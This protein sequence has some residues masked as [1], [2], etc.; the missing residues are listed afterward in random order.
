MARSHLRYVIRNRSGRVIEGALVELLF[1]GEP[2]EQDVFLQAEGGEPTSDALVSNADGEVEA[3]FDEGDFIPGTITLRV[4][5]NDGAAHY[6]E[7]PDEA[8]EWD[9]F[10]ETVDVYPAPDDVETGI[11][12]LPEIDSEGENEGDILKV[13]MGGPVWAPE[14]GETNDEL[15]VKIVYDGDSRMLGYNVSRAESIPA[16]IE[17]MHDTDTNEW[18]VTSENEQGIWHGRNVATSG[19]QI[20]DLMLKAH[21]AIDALIGQQSFYNKPMVVLWIGHNDFEDYTGA[22]YAAAVG[23]YVAARQAVGLKVAVLTEVGTYTNPTIDGVRTDFN[24]ALLNGDTGADVVVDTTG[25]TELDDRSDADYY[26]DAVHMTAAGYALIADAINTALVAYWSDPSN[27]DTVPT[28][29]ESV[30]LDAT[31]KANVDALPTLTEVASNTFTGTFWPYYQGSNGTAGPGWIEVLTG[32]VPELGARI[33][34]TITDDVISGED[35]YTGIVRDYEGDPVI[36][37]IPDDFKAHWNEYGDTPAGVPVSV[38]VDNYPANGDTLVYNSDAA[39]L[40][41]APNRPLYLEGSGISA[42][43]DSDVQA[44]GLTPVDGMSV[45]VLDTD[46][47]NVFLSVRAGGDWYTTNVYID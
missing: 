11:A 17:A 38:V 13:V 9:A 35:T 15:P 20:D 2:I 18:W 36:N 33:T 28:V 31:Q 32:N 7:S 16:L 44:A 29:F 27:T 12:E 21:M 24:T 42:A 39:A 40:T 47:P 30:V 41:L 25:I 10:D 3:W 5:D 1:D 45:V 4:S 34:V 6:P 46:G 8:L 37:F 14:D 19:G 23:E 26:F 22:E 43:S